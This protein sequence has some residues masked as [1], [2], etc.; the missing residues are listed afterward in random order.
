MVVRDGVSRRDGGIETPA[1]KHQKPH[2]YLLYEAA[3]H[4]S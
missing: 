1:G 2:E 4:V 3:S